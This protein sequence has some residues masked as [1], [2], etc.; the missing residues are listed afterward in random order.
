M[1]DGRGHGATVAPATTRC[2]L[3]RLRGGAA[4]G[5]VAAETTSAP[6]GGVRH[7]GGR[8]L[9]VRDAAADSGASHTSRFRQI[10]AHVAA[11][12]RLRHRREYNRRYYC[13]ILQ[14]FAWSCIPFANLGC[15]QTFPKSR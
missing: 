6:G 10:L 14:C 12:R 8:A 5:G 1:E 4:G 11:P 9:R 15:S 13:Q 2:G 7:G 3:G